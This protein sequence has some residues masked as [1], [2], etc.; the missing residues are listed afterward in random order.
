MGDNV[1]S[2]LAALV[3]TAAAT[4]VQLLVTDAWARAKDSIVGLWRTTHPTH[5]DSVVTALDDTR[6]ALRAGGDTD[7]RVDEWRERLTRLATD[8][9]DLARALFDLLAD[10]AP[11]HVRMT[12]HATDHGRVYQAG[13]DLSITER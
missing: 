13:R 1:D 6:A 8:E 2:E 9:P 4:L 7:A 11:S 3:P 10:L 12:A 5:V